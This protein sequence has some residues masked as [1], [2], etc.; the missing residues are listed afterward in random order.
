M[1]EMPHV[2]V[3][4]LK[5][6]GDVYDQSIEYMKIFEFTTCQDMNTD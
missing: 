5:V 2:G 3:N 6:R 4:E 1:P